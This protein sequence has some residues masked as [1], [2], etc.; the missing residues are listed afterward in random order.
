M[1]PDSCLLSL[2]QISRKLTE[3]IETNNIK[4]VRDLLA[5]EQAKNFINLADKF[6]RTALH[7]AIICHDDTQ[8]ELVSILCDAGADINAVDCWG[9]T[10]LHL[11]CNGKKAGCVRTLLEKGVDISLKNE[12]DKTALDCAIEGDSESCLQAFVEKYPEFQQDIE[13][14]KLAFN[15]E[16]IKAAI[17][18][19]DIQYALS[20][21]E[22][23]QVCARGIDPEGNTLLHYA[24]FCRHDNIINFLKKLCDF[25][26]N[27]DVVNN[28]KQSPLHLA[29]EKGQVD[30]IR[31]LLEYR[32]NIVL[33]DEDNRTAPHLAILLDKREC[34]KVFIDMYPSLFQELNTSNQNLMHIAA[35]ENQLACLDILL[36]ALSDQCASSQ[37]REILNAKDCLSK[38]PLHYAASTGQP[39][40]IK[41]LLEA[42]ADVDAKDYL[43]QTPLGCVE[44]LLNHD[45]PEKKACMD[46]LLKKHVDLS[47]KN[48]N[49]SPAAA[50]SPVGR[51]EEVVQALLLR[52]TGLF[53]APRQGEEQPLVPKQV[54]GAEASKKC[55]VLL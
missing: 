11:A 44:Q 20:L 51:G 3:A 33:E 36:R 35:K 53:N 46:L 30:Y 4:K 42:G 27:V 50:A 6:E 47:L 34:L 5:N 45:F 48:A 17:E 54:N 24:M 22:T 16:R 9:M 37:A 10:P 25:G 32:V 55:C 18:K 39:A 2:S 49:S 14:Y 52:G 40:V 31:F 41:A 7:N 13:A 21:L 28:Q 43:N 29:S 1:K 38:T 26:A 19:N 12:D 8:I 15:F 23:H